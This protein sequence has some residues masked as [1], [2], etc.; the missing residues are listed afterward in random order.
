MWEKLLASTEDHPWPGSLS[1]VPDRGPFVETPGEATP[2][3]SA[4]TRL[5]PLANTPGDDAFLATTA[6]DIRL[7]LKLF[8]Y[9]PP[10][11]LLAEAN[12][13]VGDGPWLHWVQREFGWAPSA[14]LKLLQL[15]E[16]FGAIPDPYRMWN[17]ADALAKAKV[18]SQAA[19]VFHDN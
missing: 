10:V 7:H 19:Q 16:A 2:A 14:A 13:R 5:T 8:H 9:E 12:E 15:H 11:R 3:G 17:I 6:H 18:N 1:G 4:A